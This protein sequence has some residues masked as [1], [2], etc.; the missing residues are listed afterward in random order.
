MDEGSGVSYKMP[1]ASKHSLWYSYR[2]Y[3]VANLGHQCDCLET[4]LLQALMC[5]LDVLRIII[6]LKID[7]MVVNNLIL[8]CTQEAIFKNW[9]ILNCIRPSFHQIKPPKTV[10]GHASP[11]HHTPTPMLD[12]LPYISLIQ[13]FPRTPMAPLNP[14]GATKIEFGLIWVDNHIPVSKV[15]FSWAAAHA[16]H[17]LWWMGFKKSSCAFVDQE[18]LLL[19]GFNALCTCWL[20]GNSH[21]EGLQQ[22]A[23]T[24]SESFESE[25]ERMC[26]Q[27]LWW[28]G[29]YTSQFLPSFSKF[30]CA[31]EALM[32]S[33]LPI[34]RNV[35]PSSLIWRMWAFF[36]G[37]MTTIG[38]RRS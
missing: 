8:E 34:S 17:F 33:L 3:W 18:D 22:F 21:A 5:A 32:P 26:G 16:L 35:E 25:A 6:L 27:P 14:I 7:I 1:T 23:P 38:I 31:M 10:R 36:V 15:Q 2:G 29:S 37:V 11:Y 19:W 9:N 13:L 4:K 12:L 20:Q 28:V 24:Q 30:L